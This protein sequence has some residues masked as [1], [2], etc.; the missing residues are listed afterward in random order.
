[1]FCW[2]DCNT[3]KEILLGTIEPTLVNFAKKK[4]KK[5]KNGIKGPT[6]IRLLAH[7]WQRETTL[8]LSKG[9]TER[10]MVKVVLLASMCERDYS[11]L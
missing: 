6:F 5:K 8:R 2:Y 4:K 9:P 3:R 11:I 1:M 10:F 7:A